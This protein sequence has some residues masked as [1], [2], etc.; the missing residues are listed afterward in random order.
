[1]VS[2]IIPIFNTAKYLRKCVDSVLGQTYKDIECVL[3]NDGSTDG[4]IVL[5]QEYL[6]KDKR[7]VLIDKSNEG[8]DKARFD[9]LFKAKGEYVMFVDSDDWLE[10]KAVESLW[11][12]MMAAGGDVDMVVGQSRNV[13]KLSSFWVKD[14]RRKKFLNRMITNKEIM[15]KYFLSFFGVNMLPV[16]MWATL[17]RR[18][19]ID[20]ADLKPCGLS[21]GEDLVFNMHLLPYVR[22]YYII[23]KCIYNYR[24]ETLGISSKYL[25]KWLENARLLFEK[26]LSCIKNFNYVRAYK[27]QLIE[28][29]NYLKTY[30]ELCLKDDNNIEGRKQ[31]LKDELGQL[32]YKDLMCLKDMGYQDL[33]FVEAVSRCD[34]D[35]C[36]EIIKERQKNKTLQE[37]ITRMLIRAL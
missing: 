15:D 24:R 3:V 5:C 27:W 37:R 23:D 20:K 34:A 13:Y 31:L 19:V 18:S 26:K 33:I 35:A 11:I 1:M 21:F 28:M 12:S 10:Q 36:F 16:G 25:D 6:N 8:V 7:V 30:I 22:Q 29:V 17:Y 14:W 4:S 32:C 2:I 9:G